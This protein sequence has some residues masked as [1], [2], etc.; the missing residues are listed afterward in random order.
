MINPMS[1]LG[2]DL[3]DW[4]VTVSCWACKQDRRVEDT[5]RTCRNHPRDT[6]TLPLR[7]TGGS[8]HEALRHLLS[9]A[10][11]LCHLSP[12]PLSIRTD[13]FYLSCPESASIFCTQ[14]TM[15]RIILISKWKARLK[16]WSILP[17]F[18]QLTGYRTRNWVPACCSILNRSPKRFSREVF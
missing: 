17:W 7:E 4:K 10:W 9:W 8:S 13:T 16:M 11:L 15:G 1:S 18:L 3:R 6:P 14:K 2:V 5:E 12:F